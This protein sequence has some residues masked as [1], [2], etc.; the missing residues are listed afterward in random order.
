V[1]NENNRQAKE[2]P[3]LNPFTNF[4]QSDKSACSLKHVAEEEL[5][6]TEMKMNICLELT[7][8]TQGATVSWDVTL[9][10]AVES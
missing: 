9:Y 3:S 10:S 1:L 2:W 8:R 5:S 4:K 6:K 7:P